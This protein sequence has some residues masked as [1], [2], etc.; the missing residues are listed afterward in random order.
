M[1]AVATEKPT[2]LKTFSRHHAPGQWRTPLPTKTGIAWLNDAAAS[3][4]KATPQPLPTVQVR[5]YRLVKND[6]GQFECIVAATTER[7]REYAVTATTRFSGKVD[8]TDCSQLDAWMAGEDS[9]LRESDAA[10]LLAVWA[11]SINPDGDTAR[12]AAIALTLRAAITRGVRL[13]GYEGVI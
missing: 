1:S 7:T 5:T 6:E 9:A 2:S 13:E 8:L 3:I 10:S 11:N 12:T 4:E